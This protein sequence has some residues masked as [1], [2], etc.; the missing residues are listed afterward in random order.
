M[1]NKS[2]LFSGIFSGVVGMAIAI[3]GTNPT[4]AFILGV[5]TAINVSIFIYANSK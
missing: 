3:V 5:L 1:K 2:N 4:G